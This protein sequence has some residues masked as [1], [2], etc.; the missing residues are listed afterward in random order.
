MS[1]KNFDEFLA[2]G[3]VKKQTPNKHR[4]FSLFKEA[5]DKRKF[6][7]AAL[8]NISPQQMHF[9]FIVD[10][11]YDIIMELIR[12]KMFI[13][14]YNAGNSH[15]AEVSY[16]KNIG[17][18]ESDARFMDEIRYYRNGIKYYGTILDKEYA[19]KVFAFLNKIYPL[20]KKISKFK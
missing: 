8:K 5:E 3:I 1:L 19:E 14:G 12:A 9:N 10:S 18:F 15:Q 7:D 13:D 20:L 4:A 6:L 11:C 2:S 17:F 16:M